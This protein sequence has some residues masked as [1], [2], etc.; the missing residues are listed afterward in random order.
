M[1]PNSTHSA[2]RPARAKPRLIRGSI[3]LAGLLAPELSPEPI[4]WAQVAFRQPGRS[5][6]PTTRLWP[7][8]E[9][10]ES[11][12]INDAPVAIHIGESSVLRTLVR[13]LKIRSLRATIRN[14]S[15][16][17]ETTLP[18]IKATN[19]TQTIMFTVVA[20]IVV[21]ILLTTRLA[22][23][24]HFVALLAAFMCAGFLLC[25]L[26]DYW[27]SKRAKLVYPRWIH[28]TPGTLRW[29]ESTGP[30][31]QI[32]LGADAR[33]TLDHIRCGYNGH[34]EH[35]LAALIKSVNRC[36]PPLSPA[37]RFSHA[38]G[39]AMRWVLLFMLV[40]SV[41]LAAALMLHPG[42]RGNLS[43]WHILLLALLPIYVMLIFIAF[44]A[45]SR[46]IARMARRHA[47]R[48]ARRH[49]TD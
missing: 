21:A 30:S 11:L 46:L 2:A 41:P 12:T 27:Y 37:R 13:R 8:N 3:T 20:L 45:M 23:E 38:L 40:G 5:G 39:H 14:G 22:P 26:I 49:T 25:D 34:V 24:E 10:G 17:F 42:T 19:R 28:I 43:P 4:P 29:R 15:L 16:N 48:T 7:M 36:V 44:F 47:R 31:Q 32:A 35:I 1:H 18:D 9:A 33:S 6:N